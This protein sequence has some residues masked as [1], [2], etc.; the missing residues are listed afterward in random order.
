M[1]K[2]HPDNADVGNM[3]TLAQEREHDLY[4]A[5]VMGWHGTL[6]EGDPRDSENPANEVFVGESNGDDARY[7]ALS[8][9]LW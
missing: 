3:Y 4:Y 9:T 8:S 6:E 2:G 1:L 7:G 5:R